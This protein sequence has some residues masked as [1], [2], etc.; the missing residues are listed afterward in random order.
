MKSFILIQALILLIGSAAL[1][2]F[3]SPHNAWSFAAGAGVMLFNIAALWI[4][5][6]RVIQKKLIALALAI[7]V[8]KYAILGIIIYQLLKAPWVSAIWLSAGFGTLMLAS[9]F[10]SLFGNQSEDSCHSA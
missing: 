5:W 4:L 6:S 8:L 7:I 10:Y 2:I 9:L 3:N 1:H